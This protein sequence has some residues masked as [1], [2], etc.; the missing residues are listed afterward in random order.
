MAFSI[1]PLVLGGA[2]SLVDNR[3]LN[4]VKD[5]SMLSDPTPH[6]HTSSERKLGAANLASSLMRHRLSH[7]APISH[8]RSK[9]NAHGGV[10]SSV[11]NPY[12]N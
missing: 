3:N 9:G 6:S 7:H 10:L 2:I 12:I 5:G 11:Q 1:C 8:E 4:K